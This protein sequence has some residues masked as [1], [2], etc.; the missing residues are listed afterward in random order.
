[1]VLDW[2]GGYVH[3]GL[4][5]ASNATL[6]LS[7][8]A[9]KILG[10]GFDGVVTNWGTTIWTGGDFNINSSTC[11]FYNQPGALFDIQGNLNVTSQPHGPFYNAGLFQK[12]GGSGSSYLAAAFYNSGTVSV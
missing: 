4:T 6:N 3:G 5:V 2:L 10:Y 8:A 12:S 11:A 1:G 9:T 7:G